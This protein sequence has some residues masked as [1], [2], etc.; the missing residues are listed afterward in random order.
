MAQLVFQELV[1]PFEHVSGVEPVLK[2]MPKEEFVF[3]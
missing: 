1:F 3:F 2:Q